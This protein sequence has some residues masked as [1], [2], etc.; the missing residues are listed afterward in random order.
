MQIVIWSFRTSIPFVI[1]F[2][3]VAGLFIKTTIDSYW[4]AT[5][6]FNRE[7]MGHIRRDNH[8]G[9]RQKS[10]VVVALDPPRHTNLVIRHGMS[11][12]DLNE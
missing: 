2:D 8:E 7:I 3:S 11:Y 10:V 4:A 6:K 5:A 9:Y 12:F 1:H